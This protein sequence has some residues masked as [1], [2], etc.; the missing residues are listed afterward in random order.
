MS[1]CSPKLLFP[2]LFW[3]GFKKCCYKYL[4][5]LLLLD[6]H[7]YKLKKGIL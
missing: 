4:Q 6:E 5:H 1:T 3:P 7:S 2:P